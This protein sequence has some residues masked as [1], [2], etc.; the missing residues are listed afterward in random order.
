MTKKRLLIVGLVVLLLSGVLLSGCDQTKWYDYSA[1]TVLP[2]AWASLSSSGFQLD[3]VYRGNNARQILSVVANHLGT[4]GGGSVEFVQ[5]RTYDQVIN[6]LTPYNLPK[7]IASQAEGSI[8][9]FIYID[10][11]DGMWAIFVEDTTKAHRS[12]VSSDILKNTVTPQ[13]DGSVRGEAVE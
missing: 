9:A 6:W 11:N 12:I 13:Q 4:Y 5:K 2:S 8:T 1:M 3:T 7:S 10:I